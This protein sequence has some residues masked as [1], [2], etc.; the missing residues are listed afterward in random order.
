MMR[1]EVELDESGLQNSRLQSTAS[2]HA[3]SP[4]RSMTSTSTRTS[5]G[6]PASATG[7]HSPSPSPSWNRTKSKREKHGK[8]GM[9]ELERKYRESQHAKHDARDHQHQAQQR[10]HR[11]SRP[12]RLL[13][14]LICK[15]VKVTEDHDR[16]LDGVNKDSHSTASTNRTE[17]MMM[18]E[19]DENNRNMSSTAES[20]VKR[21]RPLPPPK[22]YNSFLS[23][24]VQMG[25]LNASTHTVSPD[26]SPSPSRPSAISATGAS[27]E[28]ATPTATGKNRYGAGQ[29]PNSAYRGSSNVDNSNTTYTG[30]NRKKSKERMIEEV[31]TKLEID[32]QNMEQNGISFRRNMP[33]N[34]LARPTSP[35]GELLEQQQSSS[36][37]QPRMIQHRHKV[38]EGRYTSRPQPHHEDDESTIRSPYINPAHQRKNVASAPGKTTANNSKTFQ[39]RKDAVAW[40]DQAALRSRTMTYGNTDDSSN[41][42]SNP[43]FS[44]LPRNETYANPKDVQVFEAWSGPFGR[45]NA[46]RGAA[47]LPEEESFLTVAS[48]TWS[49]SPPQPS[50]VEDDS[51]FASLETNDASSRGGNHGHSFHAAAGGRNKARMARQGRNDHDDYG[52]AAFDE[53]SE[54]TEGSSARGDYVD[55]NQNDS[56][57]ECDDTGSSSSSLS[58]E[59]DEMSEL[60]GTSSKF[61]ITNSNKPLDI[62]EKLMLGAEKTEEEDSEYDGDDASRPNNRKSRTTIKKSGGGGGGGRYIPQKYDVYGNNNKSTRQPSDLSNMTPSDIGFKYASMR[63]PS[64]LSY[65]MKDANGLSLDDARTSSY[66]KSDLK[67][68][69]QLRRDIST[70]DRSV[71]SVEMLFNHVFCSDND[72]LNLNDWL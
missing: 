24:E 9:V 16:F 8:D 47:M 49:N 15:K 69:I 28:T 35:P 45:A 26:H 54:T 62:L 67:K 34:N 20:P 50:H 18:T 51:V 66:S 22:I 41:N 3:V 71:A 30:S 63:E 38:V 39:H 2:P 5:T 13:K 48:S 65:M 4:D 46:T 25:P 40:G 53:H 23:T 10:S 72:R 33:K 11:S 12:R 42:S 43:K 32:N 56:R 14:K 31:L 60:T 37:P 68:L 36:K 17:V 55:G 57:Y 19:N 27:M 59:D 64:D 70:G 29:Q 44:L 1:V 58:R 7:A 21:N 52:S 61:R 6:I